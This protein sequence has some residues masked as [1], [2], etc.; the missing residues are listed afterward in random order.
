[1]F[2]L[3]RH[4]FV[5]DDIKQIIDAMAY[6]KLNRLHLHLTDDQGWRIAIASWPNLT[7]IGGST[8]V[9]GGTGGFYTQTQYTD[10]VNYAQSRHII[11]V[12]EIDMPGHCNAALASYASLNVNDTAPPLY[13]G[14]N[15]G[16]SAMAV[17]KAITYSF[18]DSV[19]Q[20]LASITP[21]PYIHLGGD[22]SSTLSSS[23]YINFIQQVQ[24]IVQTHGK[25]LV[26]WEE[27]SQATLLSSSVAQHWSSNLALN[28]FSQ[29]AKV[30]MSPASKTYLDMKYNSSSPFGQTWAG[31]IEVE[32]AYDW[33]PATEVNGIPESG[34]LGVEAP[35]WTELI[36]TI[37]N[38]EFMIFPRLIG[39]AEIGWSPQASR[40]WSDYKKRL[41]NHGPRL[42]AM[43][44]NFYSSSEVW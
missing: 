7:T 28:A 33:D 31:M 10:I 18:V 36:T 1:M 13:T 26:G 21:G 38:A 16:F 23:D 9:G 34:I 24:T 39:H 27:I 19:V 14:T 44:V 35:L 3:A 37:A 6:Y 32:D 41:A 42:T 2:D 25:Q 4:F 22:E 43:G 30:I 29:G 8:E 11:I 15:V 12:P 17:N 40:N 20:E 5:E